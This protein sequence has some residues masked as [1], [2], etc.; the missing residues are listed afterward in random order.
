MVDLSD[1]TEGQRAEYERGYGRG[2]NDAREAGP[3]DH[4]VG[5]AFGG[6]GVLLDILGKSTNQQGYEQGQKDYSQGKTTKK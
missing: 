6:V 3:I 4:V 5:P 2:V 1:M